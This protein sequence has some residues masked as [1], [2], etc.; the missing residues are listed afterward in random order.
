MRLANPYGLGPF[1][2]ETGVGGAMGLRAR[3][4]CTVSTFAASSLH[5]ITRITPN[6]SPSSPTHA[7]WLSS[8]RLC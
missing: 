3:L 7:R 1:L 6:S 8:P 2:T 5:H 4:S